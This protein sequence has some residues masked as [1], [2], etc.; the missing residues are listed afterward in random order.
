VAFLPGGK[1][2]VFGLTKLGADKATCE[3]WREPCG[4]V[5]PTIRRTA[6]ETA[7]FAKLNET[8]N[9]DVTQAVEFALSDLTRPTDSLKAESELYD[10]SGCGTQ[11]YPLFFFCLVGCTIR[12][13]YTEVLAVIQIVLNDLSLFRITLSQ[14]S[15]FLLTSL[16]LA[17]DNV[18]E[19]DVDEV[20][21][22]SERS[23]FT[24]QTSQGFPFQAA[25]RLN[26]FACEQSFSLPLLK[27][28]C[29]LQLFFLFSA[30]LIVNAIIDAP[31]TAFTQN[32]W[33]DN[34]DDELK[35]LCDVILRAVR[36]SPFRFPEN[37]RLQLISLARLVVNTENLAEQ[38]CK[39]MMTFALRRV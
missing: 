35:R 19:D 14:N 1:N 6:A 27:L 37:L 31:L 10:V 13:A 32:L 22:H 9:D 11:V 7:A 38:A 12:C 36:A 30:V 26:R 18:M 21:I 15:V 3:I 17:N 5:P 16:H 28:V 25:I 24:F 20:D 8:E 39:G 29:D 33:R 2:A 34:D 23:I 4:R